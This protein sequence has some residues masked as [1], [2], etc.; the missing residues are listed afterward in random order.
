MRERGAGLRRSREDKLAHLRQRG[1]DPFP[2]RYQRG[3][4]TRE[5]VTLFQQEEERLGGAARAGEV[6]VAGR[7][8]SLRIMGKAAFLD[9]RDGSGKIQAHLRQDM[10]GDQ[11]QL[12]RELD[13]G[14][15]LGVMGPLFRTRTGEI[16]VEA[17]QLTILSKSLRPLPEKWHGLRDVEQRYRQRY[18]DLISNPD[19]KNVF[20]QRSNIIASIRSFLNAR[21]FVEVDTPVLVPVAAG[22]LARPFVT[23]HHALDQ[24][25]YLRIATELYLKRLI[26]GGFDKVYE[27]GRVF[28]NEGMD[29]DHNPEF[30]M[31]ESYE[32]YADYN[33]VMNMVE[34]M[35]C[36]AALEAVGTSRVHYREHDIELTPPWQKIGFC[37]AIHKYSGIDLAPF[38]YD[39]R[40]T[41]DLV[42][43]A[44]SRG[45]DL[46]NA[47][48]RV[49]DKLFSLTVEP[50]LIQPTFV[51]DYP[52]AMSPLAK[53]KE[54]DKYLV[55]R[56]EG[57]AGG[58]EIAN[59]YTEL[60]DPDEQRKRFR[61]QE[62]WRRQFGEEE[63]E[64]S[65]EDFLE[66]LA[67]GMPPTGG[68]GM[69]IDRLVMLLT[70]QPTIRDAMLFPQ[71]RSLK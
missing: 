7:V 43:E 60:N 3:S 58:M 19:L 38:I 18:V 2:H 23:Q 44:R 35:V 64:R 68:L 24:E 46:G 31:L 63:A 29:Q 51:L 47:G 69:G 48:L 67:Y 15:F 39:A 33:D 34:A 52:I 30:T 17:H 57:F 45:L 59:S 70:G 36:T 49:F 16:T 41:V 62:L 4:T 8:M 27:M 42:A 56:F 20:V 66:A 6:S 12:V 54:E 21:G 10:L 61:E 28:R 37:D 55:E 14:D 50:R 65:D 53:Q 71:M 22:A 32:A 1:I 9:L 5:A 40:P 25:L 13:L 11:Y 26:V